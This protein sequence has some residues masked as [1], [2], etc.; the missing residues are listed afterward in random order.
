MLKYSNTGCDITHV[1]AMA[2]HRHTLKCVTTSRIKQTMFAVQ[3]LFEYSCST[4][5]AYCY[6]NPISY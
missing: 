1:N 2:Q 4:E 6:V 5:G 3:I